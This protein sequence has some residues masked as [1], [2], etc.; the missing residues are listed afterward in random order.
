MFVN[1]PNDDT[2]KEVSAFL[3]GNGVDKETA[4]E[5]FATRNSEGALH[6]IREA[7]CRWYSTWERYPRR[8]HLALYYNTRKGS[9]MWLNGKKLDQAEVVEPNVPFLELGV[10]CKNINPEV[11]GLKRMKDLY[12]ESWPKLKCAIDAVRGVD[13]ST[14]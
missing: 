2:V 6:W 7:V 3:Y 1:K 13:G 10:E 4:A 5:L 8:K 14:W 12:P 9:L 11:W